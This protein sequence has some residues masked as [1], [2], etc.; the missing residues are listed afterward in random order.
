MEAQ[1]LDDLLVLMILFSAAK[2]MLGWP[3]T[4][5][6][7]IVLWLIDRMQFPATGNQ[8][9]AGGHWVCVRPQ[10]IEDRYQKAVP[11]G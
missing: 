8:R 7:H 1:L 4:S 11:P 9:V 10:R 2:P 3:Q 5:M 6:P